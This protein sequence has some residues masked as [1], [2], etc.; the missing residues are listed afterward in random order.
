MMRIK[1]PRDFGAGV[2]FIAF[3]VFFVAVATTYPMGTLR[4]MG[5]GYFPTAL[6]VLM[7]LLGVVVL[8]RSLAKDGPKVPRPFLRPTLFV[9]AACLA[10]AYLLKPLGLVVATV[11]TI[12][13]SA[14]GGPEFRWKE[15]AILAVALAVGSAL[16]FVGALSLPFPIWPAF[17]G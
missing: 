14:F 1:G 11:V 4:R 17:I 13:V 8:T 12:V 5:P 7:T 16:A 15:V 10:F 3:G 2:M 9:L 6:G